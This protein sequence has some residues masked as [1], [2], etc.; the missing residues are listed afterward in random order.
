[1]T[2]QTI[3]GVTQTVCT[4]LGIEDRAAPLEESF[5]PVVARARS[6]GNEQC[7]RVLLYAPDAIGLHLCEAFPDIIR[8]VAQEA[9]IVVPMKSVIPPVTPVCFSTMFTGLPPAIHGITK[10]ER[11]VLKCERCLTGS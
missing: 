8:P 1:M 4:L 2:H 7:E 11:P 6:L 10:Y 3:G 5:A 9:S